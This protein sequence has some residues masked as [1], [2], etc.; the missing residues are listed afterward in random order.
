MNLGNLTQPLPGSLVEEVLRQKNPQVDMSISFGLLVYFWSNCLRGWST[1]MASTIIISW[2][3]G[4]LG[5]WVLGRCWGATRSTRATLAVSAPETAPISLDLWGSYF[6]F[7]QD[8]KPQ[9]F[10][11]VFWKTEKKNASNILVN[12]DLLKPH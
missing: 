6:F 5:Y 10:A 4:A 3:L 2:F 8:M 1:I 11:G 7:K 12:E 9:D